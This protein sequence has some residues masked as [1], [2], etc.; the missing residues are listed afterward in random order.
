MSSYHQAATV[1]DA[2]SLGPH[3]VYNQGKLARVFPEGISQFSDPV[4]SYHPNRKAGQLTH[5]GDQM[6]LLEQSLQKHKGFDLAGWREDWLLGMTGYDG[7]LD[8]ASKETQASQGMTSS[9]SDD[10]AGA[11]RFAPIMDLKVPDEEKVAAA[12]AQTG[13]THGDP[14]VADAAEFFARATLAVEKGA[15]F[16]EGF[17]RACDDGAYT[18]LPVREHLEKVLTLGDEVLAVASELGLTCHT[19]EAFPLALY[20]LLRPGATFESAMSE[21]GLAGGDTSARA[22]LMALLFVARDGEVGARLATELRTVAPKRSALAPGS[23]PVEVPSP[24]GVLAGILEMPEGEVV[25]YAIFAHCFTCGKDFRPSARI[26][27][28]LAEHGIATLRIDFS[29]LGK[30]DGE[31]GDS[32]FL[33]NL[34]DIMIAAQ[35]LREHYEA[36]K[37]LVG[38]SL[39]GAA[40]LGAAAQIEEVKAVVTIGAP[41]DPM[42]VTHLFEENLSEIENEGEAEIKLAGRSFVI[43]KRFLDDLRKYQHADELS[44]LRG[45][46]T[47][48]LHSPSD[49][50]VSLENA[51]QIY[52]ALRHP[53]SFVSLAGADHLLTREEDSHYVV[54]LIQVWARRAITR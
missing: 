44:K 30:S 8:G 47:L 28:G 53:K 9:G 40:V 15:T 36:P 23:H 52:S 12:R 18:S 25:A 6:Q 38:H 11:S 41:A 49:E 35:W 29:G 22:L 48:I 10:L 1:A 24:S 16:R 42:H 17:E 51:G 27:K 32:S 2:L 33:T 37:L 4:S 19:S 45:V 34:E 20:L 43:G 46:E 7:Y 26:T 31:F 54:Q 39:G 13:L 14:V 3:W 21:N 50:T 5:Y